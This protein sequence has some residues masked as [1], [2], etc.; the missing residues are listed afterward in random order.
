MGRNTEISLLANVRK[1]WVAA[2]P[3]SSDI[4]AK[5]QVGHRLTRRIKLTGQA[6]WQRSDYRTS[7]FLDGPLRDF[8]LYGNWLITADRQGRSGSRIRKT[9]PEGSV[10]P[11][12]Q[13]LGAD[14]RFG[15]PSTWFHLECQI[16]IAAKTIQRRQCICYA[17][18]IIAKG[19]YPYPAR[20]S[21]QS[22]IHSVRLQPTTHDYQRGTKIQRTIP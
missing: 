15:Y 13:P 5:L 2:S 19:S 18:R 9:T 10:V 3:Y 7:K 6:Y 12:H 14:R 16:R 4:G 20:L 8:S 17:G 21:L 22:R 1:N 11:Q